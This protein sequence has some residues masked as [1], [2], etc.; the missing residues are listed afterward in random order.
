MFVRY[1]FISI[2]FIEYQLVIA[3]NSD[4][5]T[6][7]QSYLPEIQIVG[8]TSQNDYQQLPEVVGTNI[9]AGKKSSLILMENVLGNKSTNT[10]RQVLAKVPGIHIWESDGSGIQIGIASRGLSPNRSWEFNVRQNGYDIAADPYGYPEAYYNPPMQAVQRIE[11]I[12]G[13][14]SLQY[15]PQIGGMVNYIMKD[16]SNLSKKFN[17][18]SDLTLGSFGLINAYNAIGGQSKKINYYASYDRRQAEGYRENSQYNTHTYMGSFTY[19]LSGRSNITAEL[20]KWKMLSQQAGGLHDGQLKSDPTES[21]RARNWFHLDWELAALSFSHSWGE[22]N[23]LVIKSFLMDASRNS[24]GFNPSGGI[25]IKDTFNVVLKS[26]NPRSI[27]QDYYKNRGI[28]ARVLQEIK[29]LG[30]ENILSAGVR[31]Y[32]GN[33]ERFR[34]GSEYGARTQYTVEHDKNTLW[35]GIIQ[36][37]TSNVAV[38]AEQVI[39]LNKKLLIIPGIRYEFIRGLAQ[40]TNGI[41]DNLP[42]PLVPRIKS[43]TFLIG[44]IAAEYHIGNTEIYSNLNQ[45]YRPVQFADLTTPPTTD[46]L[47][48]NLKD[49]KAINMDLGIRG[50]ILPGLRID[51][52]LYNLNYENRIGTIRQQRQDGSLYNLRTNIGAS[53]SQGLEMLVEWNMDQSMGGKH[54]TGLIPFISYSY[55]N[56]VYKELHIVNQTGNKLTESIIKGKQVENAPAHVLRSGLEWRKNRWK[57]LI[58]YAFTSSMFTDANNTI[59]PTANAQNGLIPSYSVIDFSGQFKLSNIMTIKTGVNNLLNNFYFTRRANGYPGPGALPA[60]GRSTW[61]SIGIRL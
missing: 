52:G 20:T 47:D 5:L 28:E 54:G 42:I 18:E 24:I 57:L 21:Y 36:Y 37:N 6:L 51:V 55:N 31:W 2:L 45:S 23:K 11:I 34:G 10:M 43:R 19:K 56:A 61:V 14:A 12:R 50:F 32:N 39:K 41:K 40:G 59:I 30:K 25:L 48:P 1:L 22:R 15:G 29:I 13:Q 58:N 4:S 3:Q 27:D 53:S 44:G 26:F 46:E 33:T 9:Y 38:F 49:S 60:E 17:F 35:N 16:G 7:H 8:K